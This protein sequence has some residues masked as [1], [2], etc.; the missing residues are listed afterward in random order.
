MMPMNV[1]R[2]NGVRVRMRP[3]STPTMLSPTATMM[4]NGALTELNSTIMMS[5]IS[6][7]PMASAVPR[8]PK[9]SC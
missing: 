2:L 8:N 3:R 7:R 1:K 6:T 5:R 9:D 4:M